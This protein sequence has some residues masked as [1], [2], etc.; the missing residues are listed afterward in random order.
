M[1]KNL[2]ALF[3]LA[4]VCT[5][6]AQSTTDG[7]L[8]V[9]A[10]VS[11]N[12][13][14][15]YYVVWIKD[16]QNAF[17][18]TLTMYGQ[19]TKYYPDLTNWYTSSGTNKTNATTGATKSLPGT[20]TSTW[21]GKNQA[22]TTTLADGNYTVCIEAVSDGGADKIV[23]GTFTKGTSAQTVTPTNVSPISTISIKWVPVTTDINEI[24]LSKLYSV[25]P[26]PTVNSVFVNGFG[27]K[28]LTLLSLSGKQLTKTIL[29][30]LN[31]TDYP[32]G[33]YLLRVETEQ[34]SFTKKILKIK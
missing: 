33:T 34:G 11:I 13:I 25:Y 32:A 1:K 15:Y 2:L 9:T 6:Q 16:S 5:T 27:I 30:N 29:P 8:T 20:Y 17:V 7:T 18:R 12:S 19:T 10:T 4:F 24:E 26:N 3:L 31:L 14:P 22:N 23:T 21:N 28:A